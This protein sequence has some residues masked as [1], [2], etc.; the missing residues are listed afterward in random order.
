M[1]KRSRRIIV[2]VLVFVGA[3]AGAWWYLSESAGS[4]FDQALSEQPSVVAAEVSEGSVRVV[5]EGPGS[6]LPVRSQ[7]IRS[8]IGGTVVSAPES[9]SVVGRGA[10]LV[11]YDTTDLAK[12]VRQSELGLSQA[13]LNQERSAE[14][15]ESLRDE[16]STTERLEASGAATRDQLSQASVAVQNAEFTLRAASLAV[17]QAE[18][19]LES[20]R[21]DLDRAVVRAPFAGV[22]LEAN[23]MPGDLTSSGSALLVLADVSR[24]RVEAE[25]D[26]FDIGKIAPGLRV[27]VT[28]DALGDTTRGTTVAAISP[29]AVVVNN[30]PIFTVSAVVENAD[31]LLRPGMNVDLE[32]LVS[33][34]RGIVVP[35]KAVSTVRD[36]SYVDVVVEGV[37]EPRRVTVGAN[38]GVNAAVTEGLN[39]GDLVVLPESASLSLTS[40]AAPAAGTSI[41]PINVPGS[42]GSR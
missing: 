37:I 28:G 16:L 41:I 29:A 30:I 19:T 2:V 23:V 26:E 6:V 39:P 20:A 32:I 34:A 9:G 31:G 35:S 33:S 38:D 17:E 8:G 10:V 24:V 36:R 14:A 3:A 21:A 1:K 5:V 11:A 40:G 15:L 4:G 7:T 13:L 18:L 12:A 25:I 42:G 27:N 22:V